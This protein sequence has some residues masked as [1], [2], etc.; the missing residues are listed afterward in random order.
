ML[1]SLF[2]KVAVLKAVNI[3]KKR[4]QHR[5]FLVNIVRIFKNSFFYR[6]PPLAAYSF[7]KFSKKILKELV[8]L[9]FVQEKKLPVCRDLTIVFLL[10]P[11]SVAPISFVSMI[12]IIFMFLDWI[13]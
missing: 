5:C 10:F 7:P 13:F 8:I 4:L 6:T 3:I 11:V 9:L 2:N 12:I 1:K